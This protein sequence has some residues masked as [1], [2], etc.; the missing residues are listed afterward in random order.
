M[1]Q[2]S[3]MKSN[4]LPILTGFVI[5]ATLKVFAGDVKVIANP[6]VRAESISSIELKRV[7]LLQSRTLKNGSNIT[8]VLQRS[9]PAHEAFLQQYLDRSSDEIRIYYQGLV[10]TGKGSFPRQFNSDAEVV[11]YIARTPGAI[12]YVSGAASTQG[13]DVL[14]VMPEKRGQERALLKRVEPEYPQTLQN[15]RIG[16]TVRLELTIAPNGSVENVETL[17]GNPIL[18]EVAAKAAIQWVYAPAP[19]RSKC[20][21]TISF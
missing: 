7:F 11:A 5:L 2:N 9:G 21:V 3:R 1:K 18:A 17:G 19:S 15:L 10:F 14:S 13:V 6:S 16:G 8:P 20:Q 12:G 4:C